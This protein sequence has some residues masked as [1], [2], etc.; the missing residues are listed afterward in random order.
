MFKF[1][2]ITDVN[3]FDTGNMKNA[4][5][6]SYAWCMAE[7]GDYIY[8][9]TSRNMF[10]NASIGF[11]NT[12]NLYEDKSL[13]NSPE[14]W[15]YKI[16]GSCKWQR[17][18]KGRKNDSTVGFRAM[19][20]HKTCNSCAIYAATA[21]EHVQLYKSTDGLHWIEIDTSDIVGKSSRALASLNGKLYM[22]TLESGIG[23]NTPYL[24]SSPDPET[25]PFKMVIDTKNKNFVS[26]L[27]PMGG[28]DS[29]SVFNNKLYV[30]ISTETGAEIWRSDNCN[31]RNNHWTLIADKGFGDSLN[32]NV[33]STGV[34][35]DKLYVAV[36]KMFP[37]VLFLPMGFDLISI[38]K[39]DKWELVVG[40]KPVVL[41][42]PAKGKRNCSTSGYSSG[43]NSFFNIYGW[44]IAEYKDNLVLTTYD[45]STNIK[46]ILEQYI[47]NKDFY[48]EKIGTSDYKK[49]VKYY[50][51]INCLLNEY[52]YPKG[53]DIYTSKDG[54]RFSPVI[55]DGLNNP[56]NYG[57]RTLL[58]TCNNKLF[59]GT[60][61]PYEGCEV[62]QGCY[63]KYA[64]YCSNKIINSYFA[65]L[66]CLNKELL[67]IY[68]KLLP[69]LYKVLGTNT[70][71]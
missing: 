3:G 23:G 34:F 45:G 15:R 17:V 12:E 9:G 49:L 1:K 20:T 69:I 5:Q 38:D 19:I 22:A 58:V 70:N 31:P 27:N 6:N 63:K 62:W 7:L 35:K 13:D 48:I 44:Q 2:K 60:A 11:G 24:Y 41:S 55:L 67:K 40:G 64:G 10:Y 59:L 29:L 61:N 57:G 43:F 46:K 4:M 18:F 68:P 42:C 50:T 26:C 52:D 32:K 37:L 51:K 71:F 56:Y 39:N 66:E 8:V 21:G 54:C 65:N 16:D 47:N 53:F 30:G 36:T 14:I 28:I 33:M 25:E